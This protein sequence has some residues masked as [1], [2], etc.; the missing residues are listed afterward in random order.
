MSELSTLSHEYA[1]S[2]SFAEEIN[3]AVLTLKKALIQ[4][5]GVAGPSGKDLQ[6][7]RTKI[8]DVLEALLAELAPTQRKRVSEQ[9]LL[10]S[11]PEEVVEYVQKKYQSQLQYFIEDLRRGADTLRS[12]GPLDQKILGIIDSI[13]DL[14]DT[15]ASVAFRRLWRR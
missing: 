4:A 2:A 13:C 8:A 14:A 3:A 5:P 6:A 15:I 7:A 9:N 1:T 12:D 11:V 10:S